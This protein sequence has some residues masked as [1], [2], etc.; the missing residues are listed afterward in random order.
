MAIDGRKTF[1]SPASERRADWHTHGFSIIRLALSDMVVAS[2][3]NFSCSLAPE[4]NDM[5]IASVD[6]KHGT[7]TVLRTKAG[8]A[9]V[10]EGASYGNV[11]GHKVGEDDG[12]SSDL[13]QRLQH[14]LSPQ[15][16]WL[17]KIAPVPLK[18]LLEPH[19]TLH[20]S[21]GGATNFADALIDSG[22]DHPAALQRLRG[23]T[24]A[25]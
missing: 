12:I 25:A 2:L 22:L 8:D 9:I 20:E 19:G 23:L 17:V 1:V 21:G 6:F 13:G 14:M 24:G 5:E 16:E 4:L 7:G 3:K 11:D 10:S 15:S 18:N